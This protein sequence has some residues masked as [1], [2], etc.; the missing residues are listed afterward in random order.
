M[1]RKAAKKRSVSM[2]AHIWMYF[3]TFAIVIMLILWMLQIIFLNAFFKSM[4][5]RELEKIGNEICEQYELNDDN[6]YEFWFEHSF[7][8]GTFANI[9]SESGNVSEGY[10]YQHPNDR[11]ENDDGKIPGN[12][13]KARP[14]AVPFFNEKNFEHFISSVKTSPSGKT[15]YIETSSDNR[16]QFAVYGSYMGT[17]NGEKM[18]LYLSSPVERTDATRK[19]LQTQLIIVSTISIFLASILAYFIARRLSKPIEKI[20]ES[21]RMLAGG[22]YGVS[23]E[24]GSYVEINELAET[25]NHTSKELSKTENL[26]RDLISNISHDLKTPLTI[27]KSYAEMIRDLSGENAEKRNK[28]TGVIIDETNRLSLL[29]NDLLDLSRIQS[30]TMAMDIKPFDINQTV[31]SMMSGFDYYCENEGYNLSV[32]ASA[33]KKALGDERRIEQVIYN[34][35]GNAINYTGDDKSVFITVSDAG[36]K[37]RF[38]VRDTGKGIPKDELEL[39]WDKY[40]KSA[41]THRR[42]E[43]GSGIGLSIVKNILCAHNARFGVISSEGEGS[44]FWFELPTE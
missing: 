4:K 7:N 2:R 43:V 31:K 11:S 12:R 40:Y 1:S 34:L 8:S 38:T 16:A 19:V 35:I 3:C 20:T 14:N 18:Y 41:N 10:P 22:D 17:L 23:F 28:H 26:R 27:I 9:I 32:K 21:A 42:Q 5:L 15:S 36:S 13:F 37:V 29:V 25:L 44:E 24:K 6:F 39:V 30:G 33:S